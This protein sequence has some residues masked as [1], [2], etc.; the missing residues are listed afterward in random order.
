MANLKEIQRKIKSVKGTQKTT[1]AMK[2]VSS[3]KLRRAE[4]VAKASKA[5]ALKITEMMQE[6]SANMA[7]VADEIDSPYIKSVKEPKVVDIVVITSDKGL[8]GG[9]NSQTIKRVNTMIEDYESKGAKVRVRAVGKKAI[10][11]YKYQQ[12]ELLNEI[13]GLSS[14]PT[15]DKAAEFIKEVV[16]SYLNKETDKVIIVHNGYVNMITQEVRIDNILPLDPNDFEPKAVSTSELEMEPDD[17]S[18]LEELINRYIEYTIYYAL[19]DSLAA[20]HG[21]RMQAMDAA[22]NNAKEMVKSLTVSYNKARQEA[23]T[24]EL[25]EIISGVESMK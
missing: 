5:Y 7:K 4:Q 19:I 24:T 25:I 18:I 11:Y 15:Y 20:E 17:D 9:F 1:R 22:T 2:L 13:D 14:A 10:A 3:A 21:A 12:R 6:I 16:E 8:C 23:I